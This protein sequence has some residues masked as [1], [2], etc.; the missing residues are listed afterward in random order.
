MKKY[1][2]NIISIASVLILIFAVLPDA[3]AETKSPEL[4]LY[5]AS[6]IHYRP[7]STLVPINEA[8]YL[9][10]DEMYSHA[11]SKEMLTYEADAIID[12]FLKR[13]EESDTEILLIPGDLSEDGFWEEHYAIAA[14]LREF[15]QRTGKRIFVIPGNHDIRTSGSKNRLDLSDFLEVYADI[16][17]DE[18][19]AR[20]EGSA[21]YTAEL[22][23]EYRLLAIDACIYRQDGST[24]G[25]GLY[26][27]I[28]AQVN[29]AKRD[30]KKLVGM[31]HHNVLEH[32][33]IESIGQNLLCLEN[34]K[35]AAGKFADWGIKY[36][37]TG[38]GHANDIS[39]AVSENGNRIFDIETGSL[40][41]YPHAYRQVSFFDTT[42]K[43]STEYIDKIDTSL[44]PEGYSEKQLELIENDFMLYSF[45]YFRAGFKSY[46]YMIPGLTETLASKLE[47]SEGTPEYAAI[48]EVVELL[49]EAANMPLY[50]KNGTD[51]ADSIE[52]I[53][54]G[55]GLE[56][57]E[58]DYENLLDVASVIYAGHYAGD[59]NMENTDEVRLLSYTLEAVFSYAFS[60]L[61]LTVVNSFL[62]S[63]GAAELGFTVCDDI[64]SPSLLRGYI[65][66]AANVFPRELTE[67][68][69][70]GI[71]NDISAPGDLNV[72]LEAYGNSLPVEGNDIK[73]TAAGNFFNIIRKMFTAIINAIIKPL[74][75]DFEFGKNMAC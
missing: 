61:P 27:W 48:S 52:E 58:S 20:H 33:A 14:K 36:F 34:Y 29:S 13:F 43:V 62:R 4:S 56:L 38:H 75:P 19:L 30:G 64:S 45:N 63:A 50:D 54:R 31:V 69:A 28:E 70:G 25:D 41:T 24:I 21:S 59:E 65:K 26:S 10:G 6:D 12:E 16:G 1:L 8:Q 66:K 11:N 15:R 57:T 51:K 60:K 47:V 7:Y 37:F 68:I 23:G 74:F 32:F 67:Q 18:A 72:T 2:R 17:Y 3:A 5:V 71:I 53:V 40:I 46:A 22:S 49:F 9:P 55:Q 35:Q 73:I 39:T 44:L 42:T